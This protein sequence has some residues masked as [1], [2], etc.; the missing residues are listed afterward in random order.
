MEHLTAFFFEG[1]LV[2]RILSFYLFFRWEKVL[3]FVLSPITTPLGLSC[4]LIFLV[5]CNLYTL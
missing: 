3:W 2:G 4:D 1:G 5:F